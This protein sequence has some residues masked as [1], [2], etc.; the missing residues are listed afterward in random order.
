MTANSLL[1]CK[2]PGSREEED[3]RERPHQIA[4]TSLLINH[5]TLCL[6][7]PRHRTRT[8]VWI[9]RQ[10]TNSNCRM[11]RRQILLTTTPIGFGTAVSVQF[12]TILPPFK[13]VAHYWKTKIWKRPVAFLTLRLPRRKNY[14]N[15]TYQLEWQTFQKGFSRHH[16]ITMTRHLA[17]TTRTFWTPTSS[18]MTNTRVMA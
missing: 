10:L 18:I 13:R 16:L 14:R 8:R 4:S 7:M 12:L 11:Q 2:S 15:L 1:V 6:S 9:A 17:A 3:W 5:R